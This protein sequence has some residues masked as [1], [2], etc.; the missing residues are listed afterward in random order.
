MD[1]VSNSLVPSVT[2]WSHYVAAFLWRQVE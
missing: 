2:F 1:C